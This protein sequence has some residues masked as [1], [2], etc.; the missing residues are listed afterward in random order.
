MDYNKSEILKMKYNHAVCI[1]PYKEDHARKEYAPPLGL[2]YI[3]ASMEGLVGGITLVDLRFDKDFM[4][5]LGGDT[6]LVCISV[7]WPREKAAL[8]PIIERI[9][10]DKTL[11]VGGRTAT[12]YVEELFRDYPKIDVIVRGDGE[13]IIRDLVGGVVLEDITGISYKN[14]NQVIH[15][16]SRKPTSLSNHFFP[17]RKLR[18]NKYRLSLKGIDLGYDI[19]FMATSRGCPFSCKFCTFSRNPLGEKRAWSGRSPESVIAELKT[20]EA[21]LIV[22]VDD[23]FAVDLERV[24]KICDLIQEEGIKKLF[25]IT[26]RLEISERPDILK[27]MYDAGFR[28]LSFGIESANDKILKEINKGFD[29]SRVRKAFQIF[30]DYNFFIHCYFIVGNIGEDEE[31]ML[32]ISKFAKE[33]KTDTLEL[34]ILRTEKYSPLNDIIKDTEGYYIGADNTVYSQ[35]Y[36]K[37]ELKRIS[38]KIYKRFFTS[39]QCLKI[40]RK[41]YSIGLFRVNS[42]IKGTLV[43]LSRAFMR[44]IIRPEVSSLV[45]RGQ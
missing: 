32:K 39:Y 45:R 21:E 7:N 1:F 31:D 36:D 40:A 23:N 2:E 11:V 14:G 15:N 37:N 5:Y 22:M 4:K 26:L 18:R 33:I 29:T 42:V 44:K 16:L 12:I 38:K 28:I 6:D 13:E 34:S 41:T 27:K 35:K 9:P 30:Q 43:C 17:L 25:V 3:A 19:D 8:G 24:E 10:E 20:I